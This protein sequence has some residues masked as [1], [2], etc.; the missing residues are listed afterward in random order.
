MYDMFYR[1]YVMLHTH[2]LCILD[3]SFICLIN[4]ITQRLCHLYCMVSSHF[5]R[6]IDCMIILVFHIISQSMTLPFPMMKNQVKSIASSLVNLKDLKKTLEVC[7]WPR[8]PHVNAP[9]NSNNNNHN[10]SNNYSHPQNTIKT[11]SQTL[12][13]QDWDKSAN[14]Q[15]V[16]FYPPYLTITSMQTSYPNE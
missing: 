15:G 16:P 12:T 14:V 3:M 9:S 11:G 6:H 10:N 7:F 1:K 2:D 5:Y 4:P 13:K 8:I